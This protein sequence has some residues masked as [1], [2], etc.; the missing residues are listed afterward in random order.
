[1]LSETSLQ[2]KSVHILNDL[3]ITLCMTLYVLQ[4]EVLISFEKWAKL[5]VS[6]CANE[7]CLEPINKELMLLV[8]I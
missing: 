5:N 4:S 7:I 1:M 6:V 3:K 2:L 8:T